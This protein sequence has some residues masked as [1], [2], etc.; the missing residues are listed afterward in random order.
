MCTPPPPGPPT[1]TYFPSFT[2]FVLLR[3][4]IY[5]F[6][7][8]ANCGMRCVTHRSTRLTKHQLD[9]MDDRKHAPRLDAFTQCNGCRHY[10]HHVSNTIHLI[11]RTTDNLV[12][13]LL[14]LSLSLSDREHAC[15]RAEKLSFVSFKIC[16]VLLLSGLLSTNVYS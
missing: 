9:D 10:V 3:S 2:H 15:K 5:C 12:L 13:V 6:A 1:P 16:F 4:D 11:A 7:I 8:G 14:S